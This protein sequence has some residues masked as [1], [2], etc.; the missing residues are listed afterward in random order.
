MPL[1]T[2]EC[3]NPKC[4]SGGQFTARQ[5]MREEPLDRCPACG[6]AAERIITPIGLAAPLGDTRY[7]DLGF[8]KL[9]RRDKGVYENVTASDGESRYYEADKPETMPHLHKKITD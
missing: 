3:S 5:L 8:T 4:P 7:R 6:E 9:V 2:Y 1:Y